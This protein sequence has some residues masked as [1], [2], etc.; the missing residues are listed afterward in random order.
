MNR[1]QNNA[2]TAG[3]NNLSTTDRVVRTIVGFGGLIAILA[4]VATTPIQYFILS[5]LGIYLIHTVI[6]GIDPFYVAARKLQSVAA[7][8]HGNLPLSHA[9]AR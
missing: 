7:R 4:G 1:H 2:G 9:G 5:S 3:S 6:I 8:K